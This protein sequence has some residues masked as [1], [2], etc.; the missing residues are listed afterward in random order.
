MVC[1]YDFY[2]LWL[3]FTAFGGYFQE[4]SKEVLLWVWQSCSR[5]NRVFE[6]FSSYH[7]L[8]DR[9]CSFCL[10][11]LLIG[12]IF[13]VVLKANPICSAFQIYN[14]MLD[15][16]VFSPV[17][18]KPCYMSYVLIC[19]QFC[20]NIFLKTAVFPWWNFV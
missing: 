1:G 2:Q 12:G 6:N 19:W 3:S 9:L 4:E 14:F 16:P 15:D 18:K 10:L 13:N 8:Q 7:T 17:S 20:W 5:Y 11:N